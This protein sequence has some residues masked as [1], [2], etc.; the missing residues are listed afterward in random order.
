MTIEQCVLHGLARKYN[1]LA[2]ILV[3][4]ARS[5]SE[6]RSARSLCA[7]PCV[8]VINSVKVHTMRD[9]QTELK[10]TVQ[11]HVLANTRAQRS[12]RV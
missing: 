6:A 4:Y 1:G 3:A 8:Y 5:P 11:Y 10:S 7:T 2:Q 9:I 12:V